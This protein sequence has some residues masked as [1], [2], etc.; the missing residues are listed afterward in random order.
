MSFIPHARQ[1]VKYVLPAILRPLRIVWNQVIGFMFVCMAVIATWRTIPII[2]EFDGEM[3]TLFRLALSL[4]FIGMMAGFG[5][6]S[7]WRAHKV[8]K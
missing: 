6:Y 5:I 7:F 1:F 2:R 3:A 8:P 4:I